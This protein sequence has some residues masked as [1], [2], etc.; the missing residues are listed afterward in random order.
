MNS[1]FGIYDARPAYFH[2]FMHETVS[3]LIKR[4]RRFACVSHHR[5]VVVRSLPSMCGFLRLRTFMPD[6]GVAVPYHFGAL[7]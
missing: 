6:I 2:A 1:G 5:I 7:I 3:D 4:S